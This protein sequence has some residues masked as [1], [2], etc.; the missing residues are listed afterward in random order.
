MNTH[1][2]EEQISQYIAG[3]ASG[4]LD[5]H[6][7]GCA[8]CSTKIASLENIIGKF[9]GSACDWAGRKCPRIPDMAILSGALRR[10]RTRSLRW[11][12]AVAT[13]AAIVAALPA[14]RKPV[15]HPVA[16]LEQSRSDEQLLERVNANLS[17]S[18]PASLQ[19]LMEM[20]PP[21]NDSKNQ[22]EIR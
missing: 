11:L 4:E 7:A 8:Q 16:E 20:L 6:I 9:R 15:E 19:P 17:Q 10:S 1:L 14:L 21:R 22:G 12:A 13:L 3:Y 5:R 2:T 18:A